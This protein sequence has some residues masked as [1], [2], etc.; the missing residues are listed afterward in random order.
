[1][2]STRSDKCIKKMKQLIKF[3]KLTVKDTNYI[4]VKKNDGCLDKGELLGPLGRTWFEE[5]KR[6]CELIQDFMKEVEQTK[7][8]NRKV[9]T[10]QKIFINSLKDNYLD[11]VHKREQDLEE[12]LRSLELTLEENK[13]A[14]YIQRRIVKD[15]N[16]TRD[17]EFSDEPE[18]CW[19]VRKHILNKFVEA[20]RHVLI[21][22]R[23]VSRL[24]I[25][26]ALT[27]ENIRQFEMASCKQLSYL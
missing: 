10:S 18:N 13:K 14:L 24:S 8:K 15:L 26:K 4:L 16:K 2:D 27:E 20:A 3:T 25:L 23:L 9:I 17:L 22:N 21:H 5:D 1:M 12:F 6:K 7:E 19:L 11:V